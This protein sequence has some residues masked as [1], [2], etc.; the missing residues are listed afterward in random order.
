MRN[1]GAGG[2]REALVTGEYRTKPLLKQHRDGFAKSVEQIGGRRV[3]KEAA[4]IGLQHFLPVPI[5]PGHL[6][7]LGGSA[8][9]VQNR[10]KPEPRRQHE[11][12]WRTAEVT[13]TFHSSCR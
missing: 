8:G 9:F 11:A 10:L 12:F 7:G 6:V 2:S 5:R 3:R 4:C 13:S 1:G